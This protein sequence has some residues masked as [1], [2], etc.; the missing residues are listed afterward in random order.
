MGA[1][2]A[3]AVE[4]VAEVVVAEAVRCRGLLVLLRGVDDEFQMAAT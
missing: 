1:S 2:T 3:V 4:V